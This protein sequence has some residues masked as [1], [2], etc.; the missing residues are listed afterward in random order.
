M[1]TDNLHH[2]RKAKKVDQYHK[3]RQKPIILPPKFL[4]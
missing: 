1:G 2:K 4:N 3:M